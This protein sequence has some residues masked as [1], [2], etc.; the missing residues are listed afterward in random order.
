MTSKSVKEAPVEKGVDERECGLVV[1][2]QGADETEAV[3]GLVGIDGDGVDKGD[4]GE[5]VAQSEADDA[6]GRQQRL[7]S[8]LHIRHLHAR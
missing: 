6:G 4:E 5:A 1:S 2:G 7:C 3:D 8:H